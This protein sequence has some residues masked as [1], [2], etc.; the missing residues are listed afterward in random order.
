ME[1]ILTFII[2]YFKLIGTTVIIIIALFYVVAEVFGIFHHR[3]NSKFYKFIKEKET[4]ILMS[5]IVAVSILSIGA[6]FTLSRI[7]KQ[8]TQ[9]ENLAKKLDE[10]VSVVDELVNIRE[11]F[12]PILD[13]IFRVDM[14]DKIEFF[15]QAIREKRYVIKDEDKFREAYAKTFKMFPKAHVIATSLAD[16]S[17]FWSATGE[18]M[19]HLEEE[20]R[21]FISE[22]GQMTRIFY[23]NDNVLAKPRTSK[24]FERQ[25][26]LGVDV[27]TVEKSESQQQ[28]F[29]LYD[30]YDF[31]W[32]VDV[33][34]DESQG[35][36]IVVFRF[37]RNTKD[38]QHFKEEFQKLLHNRTCLKCTQKKRQTIGR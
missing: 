29:V 32:I 34:L 36:R 22:G 33:E 8:T 23:V 16:S 10:K 30:G 31:G 24:V 38:L 4:S 25:M 19:H 28:L 21:D 5:L 13:S 11:D 35:K 20:I 18:P 26:E 37:T 12:D 15:S 17:Y 27:Y 14:D 1:G 6:Y 9:I 2:N 3:P 7:E